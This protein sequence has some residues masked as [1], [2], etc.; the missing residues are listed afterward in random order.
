MQLLTNVKTLDAL[1]PLKVL[2]RGFGITK[3]KKTGVV[4]THCHTINT[5]DEIIT[6]LIDGDIVSTVSEV[7][8]KE[9]QH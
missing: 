2:G 3:N 8:C 9:T 1:S 5:G 4:I 6:S 7:F